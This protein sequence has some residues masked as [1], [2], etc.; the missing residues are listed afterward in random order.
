[1][2]LSDYLEKIGHGC[3]LVSDGTF[4]TLEQCTR[5]RG[6]RALTYLE[7]PKYAYALEFPA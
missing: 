5:I 1:M 6:E 7:T 2:K 4:A 3:S